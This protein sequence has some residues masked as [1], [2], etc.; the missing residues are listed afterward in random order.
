ML[1][2][3]LSTIAFTGM[4]AA[5]RVVA[6]DPINP[7][8]AVEVAFFRNLFGLFA[9]LPLFLRVGVVALEFRFHLPDQ[10][11]MFL[12]PCAVVIAEVL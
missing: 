9:L 6:K 7:L 2:M 8:P 12:E 5:I 1:L 4:Q 3:V 11:E 10:I